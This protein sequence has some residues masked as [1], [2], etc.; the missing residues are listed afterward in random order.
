MLDPQQRRLLTE[1]IRPPEDYELDQAIACTYSLDLLALASIPLLA[2][3]HE[4]GAQTAIAEDNT[5]DSQLA[6]I[7]CLRRDMS[8]YS[9]FCQAGAMHVPSP[10]QPLFLWLEQSVVEVRVPESRN[11]PGVFHPKLWLLRFIDG[12]KEVRY[13]LVVLSRNL[14]FDRSWDVVA[15][16]EGAYHSDRKNR[17]KASVPVSE[18]ITA[19]GSEIPSIRPMTPEHQSRIRLFADE[20]ARVQF[21]ADAECESWAFWPIGIKGHRYSVNHLFKSETS[22]FASWIRKSTQSGRNLMV[23][24]P[25]LG[26][27]LLE[28]LGAVSQRQQITLVSSEISLDRFGGALPQRLLDQESPRVWSFAPQDVEGSL[29]GLHAKLWVA[30]DGHDAHV[31][32]GSAN[33]TDAAFS[34]NVEVLLQLTGK[35]TKLGTNMLLSESDDERGRERT[36]RDLLVPFRNPRLPNSEALMLERRQRAL[37]YQLMGHI[38]AGQLLASV[39]SGPTGHELRL[40]VSAAPTLEARPATLTAAVASARGSHADNVWKF[41]GLELDVLTE[42]WV[43]TLRDGELASQSV[44][45]IPAKDM[46]AFE[47]RSNS[48]IARHLNNLESLGRYLSFLLATDGKSMQTQLREERRRR[49]RARRGGDRVRPLME[50]LLRALVYRPEVLDDVSTLLASVAQSDASWIRDPSFQEMWLAFQV[51]R[52]RVSK[53]TVLGILQQEGLV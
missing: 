23:V 36:F 12:A 50:T 4:S 53:P 28:E 2:Q 52:T 44:A 38:I 9:V 5:A 10:P 11:G 24:S 27:D 1:I 37:D 19:L 48:V 21:Q 8:R 35:K 45:R 18:F 6:G 31:W 25:F 43:L 3:G 14:T 13:R 47:N 30:D 26:P 17:I 49:A 20:V 51:A 33:A 15:T 16:L 42:F 32:L 46:P 29:F 7:E 22:P 41:N 34:R 39:I 40:N